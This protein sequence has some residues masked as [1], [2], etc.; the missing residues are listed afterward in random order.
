[1]RN[2]ELFEGE[3]LFYCFVTG[4]MNKLWGKGATLGTH[5]VMK[6]S[7]KDPLILQ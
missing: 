1:M 4:L 3:E 6:A 5:N 7:F 2:V